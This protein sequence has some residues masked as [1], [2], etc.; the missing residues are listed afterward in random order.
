MPRYQITAKETIERPPHR[1][2]PIL[3]RQT[4]FKALGEKITFT[5]SCA[6]LHTARLDEI[7]QRGLALTPS[8]CPVINEFSLYQ[9]LQER[10]LTKI[11]SE[12][13]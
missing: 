11:F 1:Q 3:L 6:G 7:E 10:S 2:V 13:Q 4:S 9:R 5:D 12:G 8:G